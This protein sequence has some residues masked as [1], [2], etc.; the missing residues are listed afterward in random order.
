MK[1]SNIEPTKSE[2]EILSVLWKNGGA[3]VRFVNEELNKERPIKYTSTLKL[4]QVMV[5][6]GILYRDKSKM[7]HVYYVVEEEEK[8][9]KHLLDKFMDRIF[10]GSVKDLV[11]QALGNKK[12]SKDE[13]LKI[14]EI[15]DKLE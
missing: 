1:N 3:T 12:A 6:K 9:K 5:D 14:K 11:L 15:L 7:K 13:L 4:M 2:I 10:D 8:T